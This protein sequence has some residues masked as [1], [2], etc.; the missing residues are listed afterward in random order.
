MKVDLSFR[1]QHIRALFTSTWPFVT[2]VVATLDN[3]LHCFSSLYIAS[4]NQGVNVQWELLLWNL[5]G[6]SKNRRVYS[7]TSIKKKI[8]PSQCNSKLMCLKITDSFLH[9]ISS[10]WYELNKSGNFSKIGT[11]ICLSGNPSCLYDAQ[12]VCYMEGHCGM[13]A[14]DSPV[15]L[16]CFVFLISF[17][18]V[19]FI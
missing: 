3:F 15:V 16:S 11:L 8:K 10:F 19:L 14:A 1:G 18:F 6:G 13:W 2:P 17:I 7:N 4:S 5:K 9:A 12:C